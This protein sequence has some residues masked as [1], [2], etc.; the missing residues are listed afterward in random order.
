VALAMVVLAIVVTAQVLLQGSLIKTAY[1]RPVVVALKAASRSGPTV[2]PPYRLPSPMPAWEVPF[3]GAQ[4]A[5]I[6]LGRTQVQVPILM[7]HYIRVPP[8]YAGDRIGWGL[9]TSPDDF[10][11]QMDYLDQHRY[12]P[13]TLTQLRAYLNGGRTLPDRPVV[14]TFDDGYL[15]LYTQAFPVLKHHRFKAVAYIV[16]GFLDRSTTNV[17]PAQVREMDAYGIE[18]GA[19]TVDHVDLTL[20]GGSLNF[21]VAGSKAVLESVVGHPVLDF[22]YPSGRYNGNVIQ[23]VAA[24]G[25]ESATTTETGTL[26]ALSNRFTWPRVRVSGSESLEDFAKGLQVYETGV[27]PAPV[28]PIQIPRAY[29]LTYDRPF[30]AEAAPGRSALLAQ[31]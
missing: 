24:A 7:Y 5:V 6:P 23:A 10:K 12:H 15:D 1:A 3:P 21:E 16:S 20:A 9:S 29:P 2:A 14:L 11:L 13:I 30:R 18:I 26:Q 22:C 17:T 28:A 27:A 8:S 31:R 19:H 4:D 25:F